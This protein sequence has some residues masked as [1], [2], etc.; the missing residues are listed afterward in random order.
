MEL[1][2]IPYSS[3]G[4][5]GHP[6]AD[7]NNSGLTMLTRLNQSVEKFNQAAIGCT[8]LLGGLSIVL[9]GIGYTV[10]LMQAEKDMEKYTP[11]QLATALAKQDGHRPTEAALKPYLEGL[12]KVEGLCIESDGVVAAMTF[13]LTTQARESGDSNATSL[14]HLQAITDMAE[15]FER[16]PGM[17]TK[18]VAEIRSSLNPN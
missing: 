11:E 12:G 8:V 16:K 5:L 6:R 14:D 17:C 10:K 2:A 9:A 1:R 15:S 18:L 4:L 3:E 7:S 13:S